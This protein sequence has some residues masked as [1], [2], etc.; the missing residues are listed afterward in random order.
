M[1]FTN[2]SNRH[3]IKIDNLCY[4]WALLFGVLYF[5]YHGSI[6][7][8]LG[9]VFLALITAGLSHFIVV[10]FTKSILK[11]IYLEKGWK[12]E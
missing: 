8:F 5:L 2:P 3:K 10:F 6:K 9:T 7:W 1:E 12:V 11:E 4:L